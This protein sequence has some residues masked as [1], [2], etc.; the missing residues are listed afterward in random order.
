MLRS[1]DLYHQDP[2]EAVEEGG[3]VVLPHERHQDALVWFVVTRFRHFNAGQQLAAVAVLASAVEG[4]QCYE[5]RHLER[6]VQKN[7][8]G[9]IQGEG[10]DCWHGGQ[11]T[12]DNTTNTLLSLFVCLCCL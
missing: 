1:P 9:S 12:L 8:Q 5:G 11:G 4:E 3:G 7:S 6:K 10:L 2:A